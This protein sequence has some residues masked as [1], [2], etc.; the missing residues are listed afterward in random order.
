MRGACYLR[1][2]WRV[3]TA[4]VFHLGL[5]H[6]A[7]NMLAFVP[8]GASLERSLGTLPFAHL[9]ALLVV[10]GGAAFVFFSFVAAFGPA[11]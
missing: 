5:L 11:R 9:V 8:I 1:A 2:V 10:G 3:A 6:L 4:A 7:F